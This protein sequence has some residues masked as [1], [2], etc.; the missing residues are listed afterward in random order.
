LSNI[1]YLEKIEL[2]NFRLYGDSFVLTLPPGPGVTLISGPNGLGKTTLFDGVEWCLTGDVSHFEPYIG[3]RRRRQTDHLTRFGAPEGS[4]RVSLYFSNREP[5]DRGLGLTPD[6]NWISDF[7]EEA[8]WPEIGDLQLY[9][10]I[11]HFLGQ[12]AAQRFLMKAPRDRWEALK[13]PAGV[14]R[15][16]YIKD[17]IGGLGPRQAFT[18]AIR[19]ATYRLEQAQEELREWQELIEK[20]DRLLQLSVSAEGIAPAGILVASADLAREIVG[21][22]PSASWAPPAPSEAPETVLERLRALGTASAE[23]I[24]AGNVRLENLGRVAAEFEVDRVRRRR[25]ADLLPLSNRPG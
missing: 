11:T 18:R 4:H 21:T 14:D 20:R 16:N 23:R 19:D 5:I 15:V 13:G 17:R 10:S 24:R 9:L 3:G 25:T 22:D 7:L 6:P 1:I 2:S 12:S 8:H